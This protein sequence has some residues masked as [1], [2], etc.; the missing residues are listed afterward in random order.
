M[1]SGSRRLMSLIG[2]FSSHR[3]RSSST[4]YTA[5]APRSFARARCVER[6]TLAE[7]LNEDSLNGVVEFLA[8]RRPTPTCGEIRANTPR[9]RRASSA[10]SAGLPA[11]AARFMVQQVDSVVGMI[12][13]CDSAPLNYHPE[14]SNAFRRPAP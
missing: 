14:Y 3:S 10:R 6:P 2:R 8:Q 11:A 12:Y 7:T 4:R 9:Y 5:S 13:R 1:A